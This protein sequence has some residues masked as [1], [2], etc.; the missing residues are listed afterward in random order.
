M[1]LRQRHLDPTIPFIRQFSWDIFTQTIPMKFV[2]DALTVTHAHEQRCR[3]LSRRAIVFLII[4]M[5]LWSRC[6]IPTVFRHMVRGLRWLWPDDV[7]VRCKNPVHHQ[8]IT[9]K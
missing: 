2:D 1:P 6:A 4:A 7:P 9:R 3:R 5:N 8:A